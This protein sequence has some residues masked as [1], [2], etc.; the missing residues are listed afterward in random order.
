MQ[1]WKTKAEQDGVIQVRKRPF[2]RHFILQRSFNQDRLGTSIGETLKTSGAFL[3]YGKDFMAQLAPVY[4]GGETKN[5]GMITSC[6]CHGCP[7]AQLQVNDG[8]NKTSYQHC[9]LLARLFNLLTFL[10]FCPE[11]ACPSV[12]LS[13]CLSLHTALFSTYRCRMDGRR[14]D[15]CC[16]NAHRHAPPEWWRHS[17]RR[18]VCP[19]QGLPRQHVDRRSSR[20]RP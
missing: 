6:I 19:L 8:T 16:L 14:D 2:G 1:N 13:V 18:A 9:T 20:R 15:R 3:Q 17:S 5:G 12:Y 10:I 11:P 4:T 7:W